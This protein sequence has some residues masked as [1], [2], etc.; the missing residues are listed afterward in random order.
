M[1]QI[2]LEIV[3]ARLH[4]SAEWDALVLSYVQEIGQRILHYCHL[5][6]IPDTL[7]FIWAAMVIDA[8]RIDQP[9]EEA[10][11]STTDVRTETTIGDTSVNSVQNKEYS[12]TS[13]SVIDRVVLNYRVDLNRYRKLVW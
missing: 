2:V 1:E 9:Q 8:I 3:K 13:K 7:Q 10:I 6:L 5:D 11:K 4:L 12:N